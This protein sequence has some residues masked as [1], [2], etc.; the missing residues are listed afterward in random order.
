M[1]DKKTFSVVVDDVVWDNVK[2]VSVA[3]QLG[4]PLANLSIQIF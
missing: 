2:F 3:P 1:T 4:G